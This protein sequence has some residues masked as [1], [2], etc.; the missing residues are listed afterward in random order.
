MTPDEVALVAQLVAGGMPAVAV[1]AFWKIWNGTSK[2]IERMEHMLRR[3]DRRLLRI[4]IT[5]GMDGEDEGD[6]ES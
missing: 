1:V 5:N 4:E 3:M 6:A 2:R